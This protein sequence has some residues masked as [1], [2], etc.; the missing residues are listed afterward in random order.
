MADSRS[1]SQ[2]RGR[3]RA[4]TQVP[5]R[6]FQHR[7]CTVGSF[8]ENKRRCSICQKHVWL[9]TGGIQWQSGQG[10]ML[11][12][13]RRWISNCYIWEVNSELCI[14]FKY[15][16]WWS[17]EVLDLNTL[18]R[19]LLKKNGFFQAWKYNRKRVCFQIPR[20]LL[21]WFC[22][23]FPAWCPAQHLKPSC[24]VCLSQK[25]A[26]AICLLCFVRTYLS[27]KCFSGFEM[28][29]IWLKIASS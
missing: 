8:Q 4:W 14:F 12:W 15:A 3:I 6:L 27:I 13:K 1:H 11:G 10:E 5:R 21:S 23:L 29:G 26:K 16:Y 18:S 7:L 20:H 22:F 2:N 17:K 24:T 28:L 25:Y 9:G 19:K